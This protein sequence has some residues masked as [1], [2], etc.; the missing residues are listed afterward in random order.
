MIAGFLAALTLPAALLQA[1]VDDRSV[2]A[3]LREL[4]SRVARDDRRAVAML[5]QFPLTVF[6]AGV[7]IPIRDAAALHQNYDVVFS[8]ALKSLIA[9]AAA[10]GRG[11]SRAGASVVVAPDF[12]SIGVDAVRIERVGDGLKI[13]RIT[14]PLAAPSGGGEG[15]SP[16]GGERQ[17]ERL[18][19]DFGRS[20]A[21]ALLARES[22]T[23]TW[24][25]PRRTACSRF[26][27]TA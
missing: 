23:C 11:T 25:R 4:E 22:E 18:L 3:F 17:P 1:P 16:R 20:S 27:S 15:R 5:V 6:A 19:V 21:P 24:C 8:P 7:R 9:Q 26:A 12:A 13:T 2:A 14:V 10:P